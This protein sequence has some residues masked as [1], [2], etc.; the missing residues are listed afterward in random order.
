MSPTIPNPLK[1]RDLGVASAILIA[2]QVFTSVQ[3]FES[4]NKKL[5]ELSEQ[6]NELRLE[7]EEFF[8]RKTQLDAVSSKLDKLT[9]EV[10]K[11]REDLTSVKTQIKRN[12]S[13][14][15]DFECDPVI[16]DGC[17]EVAK[18]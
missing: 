12:Y 14:I 16:V 11:V 4:V 6:V 7:R 3:S 17:Q 5:E 8:V 15:E 18:W 2:T 1:R 9:E 13:E 10:V